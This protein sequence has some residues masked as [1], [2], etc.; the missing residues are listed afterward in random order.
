[1][2]GKVHVPPAPQTATLVGFRM[3]FAPHLPPDAVSVSA[4][5]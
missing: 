5:H 3:L 1:M 4:T 2:Y